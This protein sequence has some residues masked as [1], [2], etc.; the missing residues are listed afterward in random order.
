MIDSSHR[1]SSSSPRAAETKRIRAEYHVLFAKIFLSEPSLLFQQL[2]GFLKF[3]LFRAG[4]LPEQRLDFVQ[5]ILQI[6]SRE[7][8]L[9]FAR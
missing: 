3:P 9:Q 2:L 4:G 8:P 7:L 6:V 1:R 5:R